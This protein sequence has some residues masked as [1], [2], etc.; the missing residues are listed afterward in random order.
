MCKEKDV[1][2]VRR[3]KDD[4]AWRLI[5]TCWAKERDGLQGD[6]TDEVSVMGF[7]PIWPDDL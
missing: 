4:A 6:P 2:C 7:Y 5:R 3:H 1:S